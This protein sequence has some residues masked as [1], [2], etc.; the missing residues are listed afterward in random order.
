MK[1]D[2]TSLNKTLGNHKALKDV[3][4]N[5]PDFK[6]LVLIG[7]SGGGKSTLLKI[8]GGLENPD[9]GSIYLDDVPI[10]YTEKEL[11]IHRRKLGMVFQSWNLFPHLTAIDNI[12]LPLYRVHGMKLEEA[13]VVGHEL[14]KRFSMEKHAYKKPYELSGGQCQ[15]VA[16]VRAMAARPKLLLLDEPTSALDPLMAAEVFDLIVELKNEGCNLVIVTHQLAFAEKIA[17]WILFLSEGK[18]LASEKTEVMFK[19]QTSPIIKNYLDK[20]RY[21]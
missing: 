13:K 19:G 20:V 8:I 3:N 1:L 16:I 4:V 5:I 15:R 10:V 2:I 17:D 7:N 18:V 11:L 12:T 21:Y 6:V 9:S 14:L